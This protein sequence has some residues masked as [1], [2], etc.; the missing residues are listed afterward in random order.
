[1]AD[2]RRQ[3]LVALKVARNCSIAWMCMYMQQVHCTCTL[4]SGAENK[5]ACMYMQQVHCTCTLL[6]GAENKIA[7]MYMCISLKYVP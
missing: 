2:N 1:M 7:C 4:L 5:I 6:S 3:R